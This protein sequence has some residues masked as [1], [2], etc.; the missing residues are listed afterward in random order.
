MFKKN[1]ILNT[2]VFFILLNDGN[3][4]Y[5]TVKKNKEIFKIYYNE[6]GYECEADLIEFSKKGFILKK[7]TGETIFN[8]QDTYQKINQDNKQPEIEMAYFDLELR[9]EL[10]TRGQL[11]YDEDASRIPGIIYEPMQQELDINKNEFFHEQIIDQDFYF[12]EDLFDEEDSFEEEL[13]HYTRV[14]TI[15]PHMYAAHTL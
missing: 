1:N 15:K 10:L 7:Y 5:F 13:P 4:Q 12:D 3:T 8:F 11:T 14:R 9:E 6:F 2:S